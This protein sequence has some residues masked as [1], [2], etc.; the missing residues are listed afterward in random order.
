VVFGQ[1][2]RSGTEREAVSV[3]LPCMLSRTHQVLSE[4]EAAILQEWEVLEAKHQCL[5]D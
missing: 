5:S 1:Q 4:T 3:P 2:L